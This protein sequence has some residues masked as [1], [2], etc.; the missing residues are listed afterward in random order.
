MTVVAVQT[1]PGHRVGG[2]YYTGVWSL[3]TPNSVLYRL[4]LFKMEVI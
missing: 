4:L 1:F 3:L 2:R